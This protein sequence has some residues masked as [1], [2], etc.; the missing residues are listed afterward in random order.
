MVLNRPNLSKTHP[1]SVVYFVIS[2]VPLEE[3]QKMTIPQLLALPVYH[4]TASGDGLT[5]FA[6]HVKKERFD[7]QKHGIV[8]FDSWTNDNL[9][10]FESVEEAALAWELK[11]DTLRRMF[12]NYNSKSSDSGCSINAL[13]GR[14]IKKLADPKYS[15]QVSEKTINALQN[16][17]FV[18]SKIE[19]EVS[20]DQHDVSLFLSSILLFYLYLKNL[21]FTF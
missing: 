16:G 6:V 10:V 15:V 7:S 20:E 17:P 19:E 3:R 5:R 9:G 12:I 18:E 2:K 11:I 4:G 21:N 14:L 13:N 8:V 1:Q